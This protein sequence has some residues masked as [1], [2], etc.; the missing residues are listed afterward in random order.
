MLH[1]YK[2]KLH[3]KHKIIFLSVNKY[4]FFNTNQRHKKISLHTCIILRADSQHTHNVYGERGH[5]KARREDWQ[6]GG[7]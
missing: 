6:G 4:T 3:Y 5:S 2:C 1:N 7:H